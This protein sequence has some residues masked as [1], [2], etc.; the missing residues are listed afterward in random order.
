MTMESIPD[1]GIGAPLSQLF[2]SRAFLDSIS[3]GLVLQDLNGRIV[4]ANEAASRL[5]GLSRDQLLGLTS[6]D[7]RW[8]A[9]REDGSPFPGE[10]HPITVTL[11]TGEPC[12]GV[13]MGVM[14]PDEALRWLRVD[15][16]PVHVDG[17]LVGVSALFTDVTTEMQARHELHV[18]ND[19]IRIL[20]KY[21]ADVVILATADAQVLWCS[22]SV[23]DLM[24]W[25]PHEVTGMRVEQFIHPDDLAQITSYRAGAPEATSASFLVRLRR[26][27][28][29]F[30]WISISSRR[31]FDATE[32]ASRIV[33]SLRD[34]QALVEARQ[35][36]EASEARFQFIAENAADIVAET[37]PSGH[38]TWVSPSFFD[39]L[40][41]RPEELVGRPMFDL[42]FPDDQAAFLYERASATA[43]LRREPVKARF[44]TSSGA[45][46][47]MVARERSQRGSDGTISSHML[48]LR[49]V[50]EEEMVRQEYVVTDERYR[51]LAEN[52]A[53]LI[54][55][56]GPD[57]VHRW[58][59]PSSLELFGWRPEE[60]LAKRM[61]DFV[62]PDDV[63]KIRAEDVR[64][65]RGVIV[66]DAARMR[67]GDGHYRWT[68]VRGRNVRNAAG[69]LLYRVVAI[70]DVSER[71]AA[72]EER[73]R[74]ETLFRLV[75]ENQSDVTIRLTLG[76]VV[77]WISPSVK[78]LL[79]RRDH[80][81]VGHHV[82][83]FILPDDV[84][85]LAPLIESVD[86][87][88]H[89][90]AVARVVTVT[91]DVKWVAANAVPT[92]D[93]RGATN[94]AV[95]NVRDVTVEH[96]TRTHLAR[97]ERQFRLAMESAPVGMA[98]VDL[99]RRL[100]VVNPV[101]CT[102]VGRP[103]EWLLQHGISD[104]I[105]PA[106][107]ELD[108]RMRNEVLAGNTDYSRQLKRLRRPD[109]VTVWVEHSVGL[110]RSESGEPLSYVSTFVD[111]TESRAAHEQLRFQATH[112]SL[113]QLV[114]RRDL[115]R[116]AEILQRRT[117]RTGEHVGVLYVDIDGFKTINDSFGHAV[118]DLV[119]TDAAQRL[120][121]IGRQDDVVA[122]VGGDEFV[123]LLPALHSDE[124]ALAVAEA[125]VRAIEEPFRV[126]ERSIALGVSVGV[127]IAIPGETPD[128]T[129]RRAD[130]AL[131]EAKLRGRGRAV[132]WSE[133]LA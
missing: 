16:Y 124:D 101:M 71:V 106:D 55:L 51:L 59:S 18:A 87:G 50:H 43:G 4:D 45:I 3:D 129:L 102:L 11:R 69:E 33:S 12:S 63:A 118:G 73:D 19:R 115:Y 110:L 54:V 32:N 42:V 30:R 40:G 84:A 23:T 90:R 74:A 27:R 70:R 125:V 48:S 31:I 77:E 79:G 112:D 114:N 25:R 67:C 93:E 37:D 94:G 81:V 47:W 107:E 89:T 96:T 108:L 83:E 95:V 78:D 52:G 13:T 62:H 64:G 53:D 49:D 105:D 91:G 28:G 76:G 17:E 75:L 57:G 26:K 22:D 126:E 85:D 8:Q 111:V 127:A 41:W 86:T 131:Y 99:D 14:T 2:A 60:M 24:G 65:D 97:S 61:E 9:V 109:G 7:P 66:I 122:R 121:A 72:Q 34:A 38:F 123:I 68:S 130:A 56:V 119:L 100:L 15:S 1:G 36:L 6:Y 120:A 35:E 116:R 133:D 132:R 98:V 103:A 92:F 44:L 5:L 117:P 20:A 39:V 113:T 21:P 104:I 46:R 88:H 80:E 10:D 82:N 128:D 58:V 29:D